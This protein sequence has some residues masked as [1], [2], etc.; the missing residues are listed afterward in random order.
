MEPVS[1]QATKREWLIT[2]I[3]QHNGISSLQFFIKLSSILQAK[4]KINI[5]NQKSNI[6]FKFKLKLN[7]IT[8]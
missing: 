5:H 7:F 8:L 4:T 3:C 6:K 1:V 2:S